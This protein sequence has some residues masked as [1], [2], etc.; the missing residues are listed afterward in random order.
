[1]QKQGY[2]IND[3]GLC[4]SKKLP[5]GYATVA[6]TPSE[7]VEQKLVV[8]ETVVSAAIHSIQTDQGL[9][10]V[11]SAGLRYSFEELREALEYAAASSRKQV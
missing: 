10:N 6:V 9:D 5:L 11:I 3:D 4:P 1:M 8:H 2:D 7:L